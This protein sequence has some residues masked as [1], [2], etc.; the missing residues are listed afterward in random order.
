MKDRR[1]SATVGRDSPLFFGI[2]VGLFLLVTALSVFVLSGERRR[3]ALLEEYQAEQ[4]AA[5]LLEASREGDSPGDSLLGG[6]L[7]GFGIY[8]A[9]GAALQRGG[10]APARLEVPARPFGEGF[11]PEPHYRHDRARRSLILIRPL[12]MMPPGMMSPGHGPMGRQGGRSR[13]GMGPTHPMMERGPWN[14]PPGAVRF[15]YL[16]ISAGRYYARQ[17][18]LLLAQILLPLITLGAMVYVAILYRNNQAIRRE[19]AAREQLA[20]LGEASRTLTH[21]I[22]N[23]LSAIRIQTALLRKTLPEA[24]QGE[25]QVI[26]EEIRRLA[27]LTDRVGDFLRDPVGQPESIDLDRFIRELALRYDRR[28]EYAPPADGQLRAVF[29][30]Q[31]LRSVLENLINNALEAGGPEAVKITAGATR[32]EAAVRVM[33]RGPGIPQEI[34]RKVFDPFFTSKVQ[35]SGVGLAIAR[36]FVEAAGGSLVLEDRDGGGTEA[37]VLLRRDVP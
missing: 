33:D 25:L 31:R 21:E 2:L 11:L 34:R 37:R 7:L 10:S 4:L 9:E 28:V 36:R 15:L 16:E 29:D 12:G 14:L 8:S 1:H 5:V 19:L 27:V 23:P 18:V 26:D 24:H 32:H 22:K 30:P 17:R 20:R 13:P 3:S 35:G 6:R